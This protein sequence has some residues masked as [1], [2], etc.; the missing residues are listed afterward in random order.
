MRMT[1]HLEF[2]YNF[3][4]TVKENLN[5]IGRSLRAR[6]ARETLKE[7]YEQ[8]MINTG[9]YETGLKKILDDML[10]I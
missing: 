7:M 3:E 5:W 6:E 8:Q 2:N 4:E 9:T 1:N 10:Y